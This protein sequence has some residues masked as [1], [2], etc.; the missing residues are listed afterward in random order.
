MKLGHIAYH[1]DQAAKK[2]KLL[3]RNFTVNTFCENAILWILSLVFANTTNASCGTTK[4]VNTCNQHD[5]NNISLSTEVASAPEHGRT[6][7]NNPEVKVTKT[8]EMNKCLI[9]PAGL[10]SDVIF[11][12]CENTFLLFSINVTARKD[13]D[14]YNALPPRDDS[15]F[16]F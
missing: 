14:F 15:Y 10:F 5:K 9:F 11:F 6:V 7:A 4:L 3:R 8:Y 13:C 1:M 16:I 2:A 12:L